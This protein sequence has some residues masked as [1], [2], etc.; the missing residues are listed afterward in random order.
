MEL[1]SIGKRKRETALF[2]RLNELV[3]DAEHNDQTAYRELV[4]L[5]H[6]L[7]RVIWN[8]RYS[9]LPLPPTPPA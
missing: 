9:Q 7:E 2:H 1:K 8:L 4:N 3:Y 6:E 5:H